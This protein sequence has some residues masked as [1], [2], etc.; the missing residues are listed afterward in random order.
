MTTNA[1]LH[2]L[3]GAYALHALSDEESSSFEQHL[4][5]CRPCADEVAEFSATAA[6]LAAATAVTPCPAMR[7]R[8]LQ[9]VETVR[10]AP[11]LVRL[12]KP[13][14]GLR[15]RFSHLV[16]AACLA[17]AAGLG[18]IA[19]WEHSRAEDAAVQ[20][21]QARQQADEVAAVLGSSDAVS[22]RVAIEGGAQATITVS[23]AR[24]KAVLAA[25]DM[26]ALPEGKVYQL[27]Y[28]QRGVM[29]P[30]GL[31]DARRTHQAVVLDGSVNS[32]SAV[33]ITVEPEGGSARPTSTPIALVTLP[34]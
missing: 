8:V 22:R 10:Q 24:D 2:T 26:A 5:A 23:R 18:G 13:V 3:T 16:L 34:A 32:A 25:A 1:E 28:D 30:A 17:A 11:P 21:R 29:R 6:K 19:V 4:S 27:W 12:P 31:I 14:K 20:A 7:Q 9:R 15:G 33:G